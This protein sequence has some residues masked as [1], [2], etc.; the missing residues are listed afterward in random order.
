MVK[1]LFLFLFCFLISCER[2][3]P[4]FSEEMI[5]ELALRAETKDGR[6]SLPP[7]PPII[8]S[9]VYLLTNSGKIVLLNEIELFSFYNKYYFKEFKSFTDFLNAFLN[10]FLN[11]GFTLD[12]KILEDVK[13]PTRFKLNSKIK[14]EYLDFGFDHFF[15]RY[16]KPLLKDRI[17]NKSNIREGEYLSVAYLLYMNGYDISSDCYLG[18]DYIRKRQVSSFKYFYN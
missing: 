18:V 8:F 5:K 7:P 11:E 12:E 16:S 9:D 1:F 2:K 17:L 13:Y 14:K 4:N 15:K 10:A 6:D 3:E